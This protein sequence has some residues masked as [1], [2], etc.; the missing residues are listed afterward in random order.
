MIFSLFCAS[1]RV[2]GC[3][4]AASE[5]EPSR[6]SSTAPARSSRLPV[7]LAVAAALVS[8]ARGFGED[9]GWSLSEAERPVI[10]LEDHALDCVFPGPLRAIDAKPVHF[11][12]VG[13]VDGKAV[14]SSS[15]S[16]PG[17]EDERLPNGS[18]VILE[19]DPAAQTAAPVWCDW[20]ENL[21][22][23]PAKVVSN[24]A[25]TFVE[26][27]YCENHCWQELLFRSHGKWTYV[28]LQDPLRDEID[29]RLRSLGYERP[30][31]TN[32]FVDID[33]AMLTTELE[34]KPVSGGSAATALIRLVLEGNRLA[35]GDVTIRQREVTE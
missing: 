31:S 33:M 12:R 4:S 32:T 21:T 27:A 9:Q 22:L 34:V 3:S 8:P 24:S 15:W 10:W 30:F 13:S 2:V 18:L 26:I 17:G 19:G 20:H 23:G 7:L 6:V 1:P 11:E 14:Y 16:D 5:R 35:V 25:G 28:H 29:G